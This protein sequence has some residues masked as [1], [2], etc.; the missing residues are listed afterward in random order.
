MCFMRGSRPCRQE[1]GVGRS[2]SET[3]HR[4]SDIGQEEL[5]IFRQDLQDFTGLILSCPDG[6]TKSNQLLRNEKN[7]KYRNGLTKPILPE[8]YGF[9]PIIM[10]AYLLFW[11]PDKT[12]IIFS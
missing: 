3:G 12:K 8:G 4:K 5:R 10:D 2:G 9:C 11:L 6:R 7:I 1:S